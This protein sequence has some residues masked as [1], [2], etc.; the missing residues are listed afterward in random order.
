MSDKFLDGL[1][2]FIVI[3]LLAAA[4]I[5]SMGLVFSSANYFA[6]AFVGK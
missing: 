5:G 2:T 6:A 4:A 1:V 3:N